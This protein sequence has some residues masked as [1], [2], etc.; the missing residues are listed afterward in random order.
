MFQD[1]SARQAYI[2]TKVAVFAAV[3]LATWPLANVFGAKAWWALG[4]FGIVLAVITAGV[5]AAGKV[6]GST[7]SEE[8]DIDSE[9]SG[10]T[11]ERPVVLPIEDRLDL[12]SFPPRDIPEV[13]LDYLEAAHA[14]GFLE[15]R[16]IHGRGIGVQRERIR[17]VLAKHHLVTEFYDA[18]PS[19]GGWGA[20][21]AHL[22]QQET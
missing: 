20:T 1:R 4:V 21:I 7:G 11:P 8:D 10:E 9:P 3:A 14:H 19:G 17:S 22:K 18:P 6:V 13:V 16:L 12:H 15:V 2:L 5:L